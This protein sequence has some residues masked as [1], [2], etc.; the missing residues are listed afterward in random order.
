MIWRKGAKG[1]ERVCPAIV[2]NASIGGVQLRARKS[3]KESEELTLEL[4][5]DA[6]PL[7]LPGD[8]R[9]SHNGTPDGAITIGFRFRPKTAKERQELAR[10]VMSLRDRIT[11]PA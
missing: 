10:F 5:G 1:S 11:F 9:Y 6:G 7:F 4:A 8:V 3:F 2:T